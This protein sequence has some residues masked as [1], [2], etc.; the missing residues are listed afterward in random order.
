MIIPGVSIINWPPM[1]QIAT[2]GELLSGAEVIR[3]NELFG[4]DR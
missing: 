1:M 2:V 4:P 3:K